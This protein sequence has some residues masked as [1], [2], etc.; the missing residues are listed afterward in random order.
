MREQG[1]GIGSFW[2]TSADNINGL[3]TDGVEK[4]YIGLYKKEKIRV[5]FIF[6][7]GMF[8]FIPRFVMSRI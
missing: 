3:R 8:S 6:K 7:L 1:T 4:K 5:Q 2:M